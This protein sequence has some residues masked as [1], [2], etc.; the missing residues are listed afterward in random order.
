M[1]DRCKDDQEAPD[2]PALFATIHFQS[3][4]RPNGYTDEEIAELNDRLN[5]EK[6][7]TNPG[8]DG[9]A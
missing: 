1:S 5:C 9:P 2:I 8:A 4:R 6:A 7:R 3:D